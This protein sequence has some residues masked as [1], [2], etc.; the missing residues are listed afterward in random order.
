MKRIRR[1]RRMGIR[2]CWGDTS[3]GGYL[4]PER[5]SSGT[6]RCVTGWDARVSASGPWVTFP[7][8]GQICS[9]VPPSWPARHREASQNLP[10]LSH[11]ADRP[12]WRGR[13]NWM[14]LSFWD[15]MDEAHEHTV[16]NEHTL[17]LGCV[18]RS[19]DSR[20]SLQLEGVFCF[21]LFSI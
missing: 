21:F 8:K 11:G 20:Q 7:Y 15:K 13:E 10:A 4:H 19:L 6:A 18:C 16:V 14:N 17:S 9:P 5:S 1:K 2:G 3:L 12:S